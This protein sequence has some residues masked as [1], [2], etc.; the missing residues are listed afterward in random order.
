VAAWRVVG[1]VTKAWLGFLGTFIVLY[2]LYRFTRLSA[3]LALAEPH[4]FPG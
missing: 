1:L 4:H 2:A 3:V